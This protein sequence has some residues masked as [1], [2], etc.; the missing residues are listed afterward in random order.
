MRDEGGRSKF[1]E[2]QMTFIQINKIGSINAFKSRLLMLAIRQLVDICVPF[3]PI[4]PGKLLPQPPDLLFCKDIYQFCKFFKKIIVFSISFE[5]VVIIIKFLIEIYKET[6]SLRQ[7][8]GTFTNGASQPCSPCNILEK[9]LLSYQGL[10][11]INLQAYAENSKT[12]KSPGFPMY[13]YSNLF[14]VI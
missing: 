3:L 5:E 13:S 10:F 14:L 12:L 4:L 9:S 7:L 8:F 2:H 6:T 1:Q 11:F